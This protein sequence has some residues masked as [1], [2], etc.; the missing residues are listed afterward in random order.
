MIFHFTPTY[1]SW[2]NLIE[3]FDPVLAKVLRRGRSP[4]IQTL[5]AKLSESIEQLNE[6][7]KVFHWTNQ[8]R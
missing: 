1:S 7:G 3:V 4:S 5:V 2:L 6:D 8:A